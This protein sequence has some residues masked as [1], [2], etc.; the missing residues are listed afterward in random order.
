MPTTT[1]GIDFGTSKTCWSYFLEG[2]K[3]PQ[4]GT[5]DGLNIQDTV[6]VISDNDDVEKWGTEAW[7]DLQNYPNAIYNFKP[8]I[9]S[10][11][12]RSTKAATIWLK[13]IKNSIIRQYG[14]ANIDNFDFI[15][16]H[17]SGWSEEKKECLLTC[18]KNAGFVK[19]EATDEPFGALYYWQYIENVLENIDIPPEGINILIYDFGG[20]TLDLTLI[21][22]NKDKKLEVVASGGDTN[23]G[24]RDFDEK[25][26]QYFLNKYFLGNL[27]DECDRNFLW[28]RSREIKE[29]LTWAIA[30]GKTEFVRKTPFTTGPVELKI[31][32]NDFEKI[33]IDL[34]KRSINVVKEFLDNNGFTVKQITKVI[35][36]GGSSHFYFVD[37]LLKKLF[38]IKTDDASSAQNFILADKQQVIAKGLSLFFL[39]KTNLQEKPEA[40]EQCTSIPDTSVLSENLKPAENK[41][42]DRA[43]TVI[44]YLKLSS[45]PIIILFFLLVIRSCGPGPSISEQNYSNNPIWLDGCEIKAGYMYP[46][47]DGF[48][49]NVINNSNSDLYYVTVTLNNNYYY[50]VHTIRFADNISFSTENFQNSAGDYFKPTNGST[51][52]VRI[53]CKKYIDQKDY[54]RTLDIGYKY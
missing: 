38:N 19:V 23:L 36:V 15:I 45:I 51:V 20:G 13:I 6:L 43:T 7:K 24:G 11:D 54:Y 30:D 17:P 41:S 35:Q 50:R 10:E 16:G 48:Y 26:Y 44:K 40:V 18:A 5:I 32:K 47:K 9:G 37:L 21:K 33:C 53:D 42:E 34:I 52:N 1:I 8:D 2:S 27:E 39:N 12:Q 4:L 46:I 25:I 31:S 3:I 14:G 22:I 29:G 49:F 28:L